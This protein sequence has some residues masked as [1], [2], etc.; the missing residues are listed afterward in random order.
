MGVLPT[1]AN[2]HWLRYGDPGARVVDSRGGAV[3]A[4][5]DEAPRVVEKKRAAGELIEYVE[6]TMP[7]A[8][9]GR[10][11]LIDTPGFNAG[12]PGHEAAVRRAF[13]IADVA[14]WL[15]DARQAGKLSETGPLAEARAAGLPVLGVLNKIDQVREA[16]RPRL[17]AV[18]R[19]GFRE[20]A[21][22]ALAL[23]AREALA[24][25]LALSSEDG[26]EDT[27]AAARARL[28]RSGMASFLAYL[29]EHLVA[30]RA[31]WKQ[32]RIARRVRDLV[33][34]AEEL[35]VR[36]SEARAARA[37]R[38]AV[39]AAALASLREQLVATTTAMRKEVAAVLREQL[40]GLEGRRRGERPE[41]AL[42]L[43]ADAAAEIGYRARARAL[44]Q[45][46]P[47]LRE[48]EQLAVELG[49]V[50]AEGSAL[51]TAPVVGLLDLAA[52]EGVRDA[53]APV[54]G[55]A[56]FPSDP[57]GPLEQA[58]ARRDEG[59]GDGY[60]RLRIALDVARE[61]LE[62]YVAPALPVLP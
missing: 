28:E 9:L 6:V 12:D 47:R 38:R 35:L 4:T 39:L 60:D 56:F 10:V 8:R 3:V 61:E 41:D 13:D 16:D 59:E 21:P 54:A 40:R 45:L 24:A 30:Q 7:V 2:V 26:G 31:A 19:E 5:I 11:E 37:E 33:A 27:R 1:T 22:L 43:A 20:L 25:T 17:L 46:G 55:P 15:F 51:V 58:L 48:I 14:L 23:S 53:T 18:V 36:E 32:L 42:A 62:G 29:D 34:A 44:D 52:A 49:L 50:A 57:L